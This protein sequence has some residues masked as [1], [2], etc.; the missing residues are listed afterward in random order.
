[1]T[2]AVVQSLMETDVEGLIGAGRHERTAENR[3]GFM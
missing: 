1:V 3:N 2:Q